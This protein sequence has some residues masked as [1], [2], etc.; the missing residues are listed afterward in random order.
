M[1]QAIGTPEYFE[2]RRNAQ[3][4]REWAARAKAALFDHVRTH[5]TDALPA[6]FGW[7]QGA[8]SAENLLRELT[9]SLRTLEARDLDLLN[10]PDRTH[11]AAARS[12]FTT[13]NLILAFAPLSAPE[14]GEVRRRMLLLGSRLR[15]TV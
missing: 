5:E 4:A 14:R 13:V 1:R 7:A 12:L 6:P 9:A 8:L 3:A 11:E 2:C 15:K 10:D